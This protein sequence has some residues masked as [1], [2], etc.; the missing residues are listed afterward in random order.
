MAFTAWKRSQCTHLA[1]T[2]AITLHCL[3]HTCACP[4]YMPKHLL[5]L[6]CASGFAGLICSSAGLPI[7]CIACNALVCRT[8]SDNESWCDSGS[9]CD[10]VMCVLFVTCV[11]HTRAVH[12]MVYSSVRTRNS[13]GQALAAGVQSL[14]VNGPGQLLQ[15]VEQQVALLQ[16]RL[17][18]RVLRIRAVRFNHTSHLHTHPALVNAPACDS[19][20]VRGG[21]SVRRLEH[22]NLTATAQSQRPCREPAR[23]ARALSI[24]A[25]TRTAG[26]QGAG[27][28]GRAPCRSWRTRARPR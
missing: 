16:R 6:V 14:Y 9:W 27:A 7:V 5:W 2:Q 13:I 10:R 11:F 18:L 23:G 8:Q 24:F 22:S 4:A 20:A 28:G 15:A 26:M 3:Q 25:S 17:V 1:V 21:R 19:E 12:A